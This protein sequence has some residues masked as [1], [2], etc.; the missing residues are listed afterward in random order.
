MIFAMIESV[1]MRLIL[2][3]S[4]TYNLWWSGMRLVQKSWEAPLR[5]SCDNRNVYFSRSLRVPPQVSDE[6]FNIFI[7]FRYY[8]LSSSSKLRA[9]SQDCWM[10]LACASWAW[11]SFQIPDSPSPAI[12]CTPTECRV[13]IPD[14]HR[15]IPVHRHSCQFLPSIALV[16]IKSDLNHTVL[17]VR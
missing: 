14:F 15:R 5:G 16:L 2:H 17:I 4:V 12:A 8:Q 9:A 6:W 1:G 3:Y 7:H 10:T 13:K 11:N